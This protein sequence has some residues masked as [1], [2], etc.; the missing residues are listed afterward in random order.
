[1]ADRARPE[2]P[3]RHQNAKPEMRARRREV[4]DKR[5]MGIARES[6]WADRHIKCRARGG[7]VSK[8]VGQADGGARRHRGKA[9]VSSVM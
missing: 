4:G 9:S 3:C 7:V 1:M 8:Q 2:W 5:E 6:K